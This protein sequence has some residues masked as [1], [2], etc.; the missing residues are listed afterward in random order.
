MKRFFNWFNSRNTAIL[1]FLLTLANFFTLTLG[2]GEE[3]YLAFARQYM[4]PEWISN[5]FTLTHPAG[6]NLAFQVI[7]GFFLRYLSFE[8]VA[9][10]G[11]VINY[12]LYAIPLA[13]IFRKFRLSNIETLFLLQVIFF[14][15]QSLWAGEWIFGGIEEKTLAYIF[16]FW[17]IYFLL[18]N[19][20]LPSAFFAAL[21][22]YFHFLVGGWMFF[23]VMVYFA[24]TSR[25]LRIIILT[26]AVYAAII[27]PFI[28][29]LYKTYMVNNPAVVNGVNTNALY[30]YWRLKH[31]IGMMRDLSYLLKYPLGG[32]LV[33]MLLFGLCLFKFSKIK[34]KTI[35]QLNILNIIIFSQQ[36]LFMI[37]GAFDKNAVLMKTYPFRT[38]SLSVFLCMIE[39]ALLVKRYFSGGLYRIA[40]KKYLLRIPFPKRKQRYTDTLNLV[41]FTVLSIAFVIKL[42]DRCSNL[43][44]NNDKTDSDM[45]NL[46]DYVRT[47]TPKTSVFIL[48]DHDKPYSF[49]RRTERERFVVMKFTPTSSRAIY[50]WYKRE[51]LVERMR[52]RISLIDSLKTAYRV[53]YLVTDSTFTHPSLQIE[54]RFGTHNLYKIR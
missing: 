53:D 52:T 16:V 6:G 40:V 12:L 38:N 42:T 54:K 3:Q 45:L 13:L 31:H 5:S 27:L 32:I 22:T 30:A 51:T 17:S 20:S 50:E 11:R 4:D 47:N 19:R 43:N 25:N 2:G 29:Y 36:F 23:F 26:G 8:H 18:N 41:F 1:I 44:A 33:S 35:R 7:A 34:D 9:V 37:I 49:I 21:A 24:Y 48:L 10:W 39:M 14:A 46:M 28:I 15:H